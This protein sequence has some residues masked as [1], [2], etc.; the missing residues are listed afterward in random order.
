MSGK[1]T[2]IFDG[3]IGYEIRGSTE[4]LFNRKPLVKNDRELGIEIP[5]GDV[6]IG[7]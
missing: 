7:R 2:R 6:E 5:N 3:D 4:P 1:S